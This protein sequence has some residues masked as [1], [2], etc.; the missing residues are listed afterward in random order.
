MV[1]G[2][3]VNRSYCVWLHFFDIV[4]PAHFNA[5]G[6]SS[7]ISEALVYTWYMVPEPKDQIFLAKM[8]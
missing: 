8:I 2:A 3:N 7:M 4:Q 6:E 5:G 1:N